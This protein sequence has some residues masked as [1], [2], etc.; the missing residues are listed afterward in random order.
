MHVS[1]HLLQTTADALTATPECMQGLT[2]LQT[3]ADMALPAMVKSFRMG[4]RSTS[5][6]TR[7]QSSFNLASSISSGSS[8]AKQ[9]C[10]PSHVFYVHLYTI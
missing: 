10:L 5:G 9:R 1:V 3:Q 8:A 4:S 7:D 2:S 6:K